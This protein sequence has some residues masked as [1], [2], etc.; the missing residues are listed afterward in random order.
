MSCIRAG[1]EIANVGGADNSVGAFRVLLT[2]VGDRSCFALS[3]LLEGR[4]GV[5]CTLIAVV[6]FCVV[7]T[8]SRLEFMPTLSTVTAVRRARDTV[9]AVTDTVTAVRIIISG[10]GTLLILAD[11]VGTGVCIIACVI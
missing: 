10:E 6:A 11:V 8:A 4:T 5:G 1:A 3:R 7:L 2:T 9:V